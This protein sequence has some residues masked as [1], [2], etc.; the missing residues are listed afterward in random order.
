MKE[1]FGQL[2]NIVIKWIAR[3]QVHFVSTDED[4]M[5]ECRDCE[6]FCQCAQ[7]KNLSLLKEVLRLVDEQRPKKRSTFA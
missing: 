3:S 1:C 6:L 2:G 5:A 7:E 4:K